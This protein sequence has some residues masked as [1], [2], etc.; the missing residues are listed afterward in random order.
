MSGGTAAAHPEP[1]HRHGLERIALWS[2]VCVMAMVAAVVLGAPDDVRWTTAW[3]P[4]LWQVSAGIGVQLIAAMALAVVQLRHAASGRYRWVAP[5]Q[6]VM[7]VLAVAGPMLVIDSVAGVPV[8][9]SAV[10]ALL[11]AATRHRL[12]GVLIAWGVVAAAL[13]AG[14]ALGDGAPD[15][16]HG[17]G[18][19]LA[20]VVLLVAAAT[21]GVQANSLD[22][23][24]TE[25]HDVRLAM[26]R[27][28]RTDLL[29]GLANRAALDEYET[30]LAGA[31]PGPLSVV[32]FDL[33]GFK[34]V[35]DTH[36]HHA[37]DLLLTTV[38][39][40][41]RAGLRPGDL[42]VRLGGDEFAVLLPGM[43]AEEAAAAVEDWARTVTQPVDVGDGVARVGV[44]V[45]VAHR[46]PGVGASFADLLRTADRRMYDHKHAKTHRPAAA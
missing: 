26:T 8:W 15:S 7:D 30:A 2:R 4:A 5:A 43:P 37:G 22:R 42:L 9:P 1:S 34:Q 24:V 21:S 14:V 31:E 36:G 6:T 18:I 17:A 11:S 23:H 44:S 38:A 46:P 13:V 45:G 29:T 33:D 32:L 20:V 27:Q 10:L 12:A 3:H 19:A 41:L 25:L 40:R 16:P 35:N 39:A 28:A